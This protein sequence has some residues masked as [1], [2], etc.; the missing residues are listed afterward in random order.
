[1]AVWAHDRPAS[2]GAAV[3]WALRAVSEISPATAEISKTLSLP[4]PLRIRAGLNTGPAIVGGTDYTALGHT[5]NATFRLET[6]TKGIGMGIAIGQRAYSGLP[7]A[8]RQRFA[9]KEVDLNR[10]SSWAENTRAASCFL[11]SASGWRIDS[12]AVAPTSP[13]LMYHSGEF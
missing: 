1:M 13:C 8:A 4:A 10:S 6:A 9:R 3:M 11:R 2:V 12:R 7:D 5:V